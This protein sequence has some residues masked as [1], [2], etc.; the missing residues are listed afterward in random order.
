METSGLEEPIVRVDLAQLP[1]PPGYGGLDLTVPEG[2]ATD[3]VVGDIM[4]AVPSSSNDFS[5][6]DYAMLVDT[7][8]FQTELDMLP[9][10]NDF[11]AL[12]KWTTPTM[13][14]SRDTLSQLPAGDGDA[15]THLNLS[16]PT[17][18]SVRHAA[19]ERSAWNWSPTSGDS[20]GDEEM[21]RFSSAETQKLRDA[22]LAQDFQTL[23]RA[24]SKDCGTSLR[25]SML[26]LVQLHT[27]PSLR[28]PVPSFPTSEA[29]SLLIQ[30][31]LAREALS[32]C[33]L[34]HVASF[35]PDI[36]RVE[37]SCAMIASTA[38]SLGDRHI[39]QMGLALQERTRL[40]AIKAM[41]SDSSLIRNLNIMQAFVLW[42]ETGLWSGV[43][44]KM[45]IA[46]AAANNVPTVSL[47]SLY[48]GETTALI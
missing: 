21:P 35:S 11:S 41:D 17:R 5:W 6:D 37:L 32:V 34:I 39:A 1:A 7:S 10:T 9:E 40:A 45:E 26:F 42:I 48:S 28:L 14:V 27:D 4:F 16:S 19:F 44:R 13:L 12:S 20:G 24:I 31:F 29:L 46:E 3:H 30:R 38:S 2:A 43:R 18:E 8:A 25:D 47:P 15:A 22:S 33:P 23:P 36:C